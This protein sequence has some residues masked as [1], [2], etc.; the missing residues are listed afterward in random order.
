MEE[1]EEGRREGERG[2]EAEIVPPFK[3]GSGGQSVVGVPQWSALVECPAPSGLG[4]DRIKT[5]YYITL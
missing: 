5:Y 2:G 4:K 1:E 3:V